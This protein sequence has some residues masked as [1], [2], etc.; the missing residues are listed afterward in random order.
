M[1]RCEHPPGHP[2]AVNPGCR[3]PV[4]DNG[5]GR[6]CG[7]VDSEGNPLFWYNDDCSL[8]GWLLAE[9]IDANEMTFDV[10]GEEGMK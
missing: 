4:I 7:R 2:E 1:P 6:G 5:H 8:H 10:I 9:P 3:C